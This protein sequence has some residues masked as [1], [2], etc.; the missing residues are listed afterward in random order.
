M[1]LLM[2]IVNYR[3]VFREIGIEC[4]DLPYYNSSTKT[5]DFHSFKTAIESLPLCSVVILQTSAHNPT[6]CD[7]SIDQWVE[8][9]Q[10]FLN[11]RHFAFLDS[12]YLGLVSGDPQS[13]FD[14]GSIRSFAESGVPMLLAA[15]FG[16]CF[17]L[18]GERVGILSLPGPSQEVR[19]RMQRQMILLA[20]SETGASP[21]FGAKIVE[22]ILTDRELRN[23][24][25]NDLGE[26]ARQLKSRRKLLR[27]E[28][29]CLGTPGE[30][31]F[32]TNQVGM[33][34]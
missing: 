14:S 20:R 29:E 2:S 27:Q 6:G 17:G 10:T 15:T 13:S 12:A 31:D 23:Q 5:L 24:W 22:I 32:I 1:L 11:R 18:Y 26:M 30:W 21:S 7:P 3:N 33:F 16:K 25:E 9:T 28:L 34:S 19:E 8:L 4:V